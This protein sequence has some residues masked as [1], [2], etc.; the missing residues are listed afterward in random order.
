MSLGAR[1]LDANDIAESPFASLASAAALDAADDLYPIVGSQN[2]IAATLNLNATVSIGGLLHAS[3]FLLNDMVVTQSSEFYG[4]VFQPLF[5]PL[6]R[7]HWSVGD[8]CM[9]G[10]ACT[11]P[12]GA[13]TAVSAGGVLN[14]IR[15][16]QATQQQ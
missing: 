6:R 5:D 12:A 3:G 7:N 10:G 8:G 1:Y 4:G 13:Q 14:V 11:Q 2:L 15:G 9:S 16:I